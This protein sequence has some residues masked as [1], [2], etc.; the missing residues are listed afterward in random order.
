MEHFSSI[1]RA[2]VTVLLVRVV[3]GRDGRF[4][5]VILIDTEFA[6]LDQIGGVDCVE[7]YWCD[8]FHIDLFAAE[9]PRL[10]H[11]YN[12]LAVARILV[13]PGTGAETWF[14]PAFHIEGLQPEFKTDCLR[15]RNLP[16]GIRYA[17]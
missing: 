1:S 2:R 12:G 16:S 7:H 10:G 6:T 13:A 9:F 4:L 8:V 14:E 17:I 11:L 5:R 15:K 3:A